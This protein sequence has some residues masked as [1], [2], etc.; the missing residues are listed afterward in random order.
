M[1]AAT[2]SAMLALSLLPA[3]TGAAPDPLRDPVGSVNGL[4]GQA[5]AAVP[6]VS[7]GGGSLPQV[8]AGGSE[9]GGLQLTVTP[10]GSATQPGT[11]QQPPQPGSGSAPSAGGGSGSGVPG[12]QSGGG[13]SGTVGGSGSAAPR[14]GGSPADRP[15]GGGGAAPT[16]GRGAAATGDRGGTGGRDEASGRSRERQPSVVSRIVDRIPSEYRLAL[17]GLAAIS[18][19][20]ALLTLYEARKSR[21]AQEDALSDPLTG[22]PNRQAFDLQL[23]AEWKRSSRYGDEL[24][25]MLLDLDGFKAINDTKG[26]LAGDRVLRQA[27]AAIA[28]RVRE[29]DF[30]ARIGGD[31]FVVICPETGAEGLRALADGL[32]AALKDRDIE[33]SVGFAEWRKADSEPADLFARAD[34]EMYRR[35]RDGRDADRHTAGA[36]AAV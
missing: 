36:L 32:Q 15:S 27:A 5:T 34:E 28:G 22:L 13:E 11:P 2:A 30:A 8:S 3:S 33:A 21:R 35:K 20:F 9:G 14:S 1:I 17:A 10:G 29:T 16:Q 24:G 25:L 7:A 4:L 19:L 18:L 26:H 6:T 12:G 31:E 23:D